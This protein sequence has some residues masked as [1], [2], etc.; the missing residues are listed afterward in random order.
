[1]TDGEKPPADLSSLMSTVA[2]IVE[3]VLEGQ[4]ITLFTQRPNPWKAAQREEMARTQV[5][6]QMDWGRA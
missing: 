2:G 3:A 1:M 4:G 6:Q 5:W